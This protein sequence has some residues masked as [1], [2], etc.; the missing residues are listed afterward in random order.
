M[1]G[2]LFAGVA[3]RRVISHVYVTYSGTVVTFDQHNEVMTS[4][5]GQWDMLRP[6]IMQ[7]MPKTAILHPREEE[8]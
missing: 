3:E 6:A 7:A 8:S 4:Y 1:T 5:T 2:D